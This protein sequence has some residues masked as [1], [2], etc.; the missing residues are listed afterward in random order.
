[1]SNTA[2]NAIVTGGASG[3]GEA[4]CYR[5]ARDGIGIGVWDVDQV[6]AERVAARLVAEGKRAVACKVDVSSTDAINTALDRVHGALGAV[7]ILVNSAGVTFFKPFLE[8]SEQDWN[9]VFSINVMG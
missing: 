4:T 6:G 3:I 2:K 8:S 7:Q 5:L 9:R 1:M